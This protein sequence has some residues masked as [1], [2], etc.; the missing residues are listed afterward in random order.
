MLV[1]SKKKSP[2]YHEQIVQP[3]DLAAIEANVER[4]HYTSPDLFD[5]DILRWINNTS[6]FYGESSPESGAAQQLLATYSRKKKDCFD[7]LALIV[8]TDSAL[9]RTFV[10]VR[11]V[12]TI[13]GGNQLLIPTAVDPNED[14]IRCICGLY[15]D[16]GIMIQCS[17]CLCWQHTQC[18]GADT[19]L[20][21]YLCEQCDDGGRK[22]DYEIRLDDTNVKGHQLYLSLLRGMLHVRQTDTVYVLRDIPIKD[23]AVDGIVR[24]HTYET[25]GQVDFS[26]CDIFRIEQLWK[27]ESGRRFAYGHHYLRP[28]ETYHEPS[29]K[30]YQNEVMRVPLYEEV[31]IEMIMGRCWVLDPITFC[32]GRPVDAV[33]EHVYI[34]ELRVDKAAKTFAKV[35]KNQYPVCQKSYAFHKFA[36]KLKIQRTYMVSGFIPTAKFPEKIAKKHPIFLFHL[37]RL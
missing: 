30:F 8:G 4:G 22:V 7:R 36:Q 20:E 15:I 33:E 34:C 10:P 13:S 11:A 28:H 2:A 37:K 5:A 17:H 23:G 32:K 24:K 3:I 25:I 27:D 21:N 12:N 35:S 26:D 31:P 9:L 18:N 16:E 14:V 6:R 1:P 29:R 19:S